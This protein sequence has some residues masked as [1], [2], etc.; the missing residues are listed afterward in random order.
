MLNGQQL[1]HTKSALT[2]RRIL[3]FG[4][5]DFGRGKVQIWGE[6]APKRRS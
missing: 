2:S 3:F 4:E 5:G 6:A 1:R